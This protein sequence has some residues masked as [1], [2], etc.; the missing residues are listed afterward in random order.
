[1]VIQCNSMAA[2]CIGIASPSVAQ[3]KGKILPWVQFLSGIMF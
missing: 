2:C 1:M 3:Y